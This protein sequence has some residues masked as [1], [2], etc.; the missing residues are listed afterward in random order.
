M[1]NQGFT[2]QPTKSQKKEKIKGGGELWKEKGEGEG[3]GN[4]DTILGKLN[5]EPEPAC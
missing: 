4:Y 1:R 2:N 5:E 3:S